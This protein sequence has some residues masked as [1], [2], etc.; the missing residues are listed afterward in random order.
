MKNHS[1]LYKKIVAIINS[2]NPNKLELI[3][4]QVENSFYEETQLT[5]EDADIEEVLT[6]LYSKTYATSFPL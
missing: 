6:Y 3:A 4:K 5:L 1:S 2:L